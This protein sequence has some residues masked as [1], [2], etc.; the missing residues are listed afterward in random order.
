MSTRP[1]YRASL[2]FIILT[3]TMLRV[4][5]AHAQPTPGAIA[6]T[7]DSAP[8]AA[9]MTAGQSPQQDTFTL[10]NSLNLRDPFSRFIAKSEDRV[11]QA[12]IPE[13]ERF[14]LEQFKLVGIITGAKRNKALLTAPDGKMHVIS[15]RATIG[16]RRGTV[17]R[18]TPGA[19]V[20]HEKV[21]NLLGQEEGVD[22]QIEF[23]EK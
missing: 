15:E 17:T 7:Q 23:Q 19:I 12:L 8:D 11:D 13:L 9:A 3:T 5:V 10:E 2:L 4:H 14:D 21:V 1:N 18:I 16:T 22:T 6:A 20:V